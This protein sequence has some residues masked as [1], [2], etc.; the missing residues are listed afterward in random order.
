MLS[1]TAEEKDFAETPKEEEKK[2]LNVQQWAGT[3]WSWE[4]KSKINQRNESNSFNN[5]VNDV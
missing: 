2:K 1:H 5:C 4:N 3:L